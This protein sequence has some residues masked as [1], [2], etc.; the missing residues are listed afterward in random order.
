M[1]SYSRIHAIAQG[2][3]RLS[4]D[5]SLAFF[6]GAGVRR[7]HAI[8]NTLYACL[9]VVM[10]STAFSA[11]VS[12]THALPYTPKQL[13]Y[14]VL[15]SFACGHGQ[16]LDA[17]SASPTGEVVFYWGAWLLVLGLLPVS[18]FAFYIFKPTVVTLFSA[19]ALS[20]LVYTVP[21]FLYAFDVVEYCGE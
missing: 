13:S 9:G 4:S 6:V 12:A 20:V 1:K 15:V 10:L 7:K 5:K 19:I 18:I 17:V 8:V 16:F 14:N 11:G 3:R 21:T 2:W